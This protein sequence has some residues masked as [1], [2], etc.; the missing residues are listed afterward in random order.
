VGYEGA[1]NSAGV[2]HGKGV[3]VYGGGGR[4]EGEWAYGQR[5]GGGTM[6]FVDGR[7]YAGEWADGREDG[8]G[9]VKDREGKV[10]LKAR[11]KDEY[12]LI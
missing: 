10:L 2:P 7:T 5:E 11:W 3:G 9:V 12:D 1:V 6:A 4:Y 8:E